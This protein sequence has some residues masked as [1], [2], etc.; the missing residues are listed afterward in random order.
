M[1]A[2]LGS[3]TL[4]YSSAA[5]WLSA[6]N[7]SLV[8]SRYSE[9]IKKVEP[10]AS[11]Q[12]AEAHRY[13]K[14]LSAGAVLEANSHV[15]TGSGTSDHKTYDYWKLLDTPNRAMSRIQIPAIGV[16]LPIYHGTSD[17]ALLE[18]AGHLQGTSLPV[19][20]HSTHSVIT[21]HRGLADATMFTDL[22]K[23]TQ[24]D[25]FI[26]T[27]FGQVFTYRIFDTRVVEPGDTATLRQ[28]AGRDLVTLVTCTPL[29]IN[30]HRILVTGR[31]ILP[32]PPEDLDAAK[33]ATATLQFPW[34]AVLYGSALVAVI[35]Y[36]WRAG[37][38]Y[39]T[40]AAHVAARRRTRRKF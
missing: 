5:S 22:D 13:N 39:P 2:V 40:R 15:P 1:L 32:T 35:V 11:E 29:G 31:R 6:Y 10:S 20:G 8:I 38:T 18:G 28:E 30:T 25:T 12:L 33:N 37:L 17:A 16:D 34:W 23:V 14:D 7:Q 27:T 9:A 21:A 36:V 26:L 3:S 24:G 4:T 19:G